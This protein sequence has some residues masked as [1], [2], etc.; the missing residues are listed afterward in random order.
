MS[1]FRP[2]H[3][4]MFDT[5]VDV[6]KTLL[7]EQSPFPRLEHVQI[8]GEFVDEV[9]VFNFLARPRQLRTHHRGH[10]ECRRSSVNEIVDS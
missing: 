7:T 3:H 5:A 6:N 2:G 10:C 1:S 9:P 4:A 8:G